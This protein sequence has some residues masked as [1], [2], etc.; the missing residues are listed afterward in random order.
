M[1]TVS[2]V[3][4]MDAKEQAEAASGRQAHLRRQL[5]ETNYGAAT[6]PG[7]KSGFRGKT[8]AAEEN[9][10]Q[11]VACPR[12]DSAPARNT[13]GSLLGR[14]IKLG[15]GAVSLARSSGGGGV[16]SGSPDTRGRL[17]LGLRCSGCGQAEELPVRLPSFCSSLTARH[18]WRVGE[19]TCSGSF[20]PRVVPKDQEGVDGEIG[21]LTASPELPLP[22]GIGLV[23]A[24]FRC[25]RSRKGRRIVKVSK[26]S[27]AG[28]SDGPAPIC[29]HFMTS[30]C[31]GLSWNLSGLGAF[32]RGFLFP[33]KPPRQGSK[34]EMRLQAFVQSKLASWSH[35]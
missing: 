5:Q 19:R 8:N 15:S 11:L 4:G 33:E 12:R 23:P 30:T 9:T 13:S 21:V 17:L 34:S 25:G 31:P 22:L 2:D 16:S 24:F 18:S 6:T 28:L 26:N 7:R 35:V 10:Y 14:R 32:R 29:C 1:P 27:R 20:L 3:V